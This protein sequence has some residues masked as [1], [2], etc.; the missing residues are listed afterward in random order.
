MTVGYNIPS[1]ANLYFLCGMMDHEVLMS[2]NLVF[3][4]N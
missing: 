3:A 1:I 4:N 2:S